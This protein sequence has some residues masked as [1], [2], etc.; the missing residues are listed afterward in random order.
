MQPSSLG[1]HF[2]ISVGKR[3][4]KC[5]CP[6]P[7]SSFPLCPLTPRG[8]T[9]ASPFFYREGYKLWGKWKVCPLK[10]TLDSQ[11]PTFLWREPSLM[12]HHHR[13]E[14]VHI[15]MSTRKESLTIFTCLTDHCGAFLWDKEVKRVKKNSLYS[16]CWVQGDSRISKLTQLKRFRVDL[17]AKLKIRDLELWEKREQLKHENW[18]PMALP[19]MTPLSRPRELLNGPELDLPTVVRLCSKLQRM[20]STGLRNELQQTEGFGNLGK[21]YV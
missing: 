20:S 11:I 15:W 18:Y 14:C 1:H 5:S 21:A 19:N 17:E 8:T 2:A 16:M 9:Q 12:Q 4:A 13:Q 6:T 3:C 7:L 10:K